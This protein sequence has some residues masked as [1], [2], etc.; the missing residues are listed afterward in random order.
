MWKGWKW[1]YLIHPFVFTWTQPLWSTVCLPGRKSAYKPQHKRTCKGFFTPEP[2]EISLLFSKAVSDTD[3]V[4]GSGVVGCLIFNLFTSFLVPSQS[5]ALNELISCLTVLEVNVEEMSNGLHRC[6]WGQNKALYFLEKSSWLWRCHSH[7][8]EKFRISH[9]ICHSGKW[10]GKQ[11]AF[12][13]T[14]WP[15]LHCLQ[16]VFLDRGVSVTKQV[17]GR[18]NHEKKMSHSTLSFQG[19]PQ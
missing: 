2:E 17:T 11:K 8:C 14:K 19:P 6:D 4:S 10:P 18:L 12:S 1:F 9:C 3:L 7:K 5:P 15:I 16:Q 13:L